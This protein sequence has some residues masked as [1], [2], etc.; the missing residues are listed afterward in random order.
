MVEYFF[1]DSSEGTT[2]NWDIF[3]KFFGNDESIWFGRGCGTDIEGTALNVRV[4]DFLED[5]VIGGR[6]SFT[7]KCEV[8]ILTFFT[9]STSSDKPQT[10]NHC[11]RILG[12]LGNLKNNIVVRHIKHQRGINITVFF[13]HYYDLRFY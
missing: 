5:P 1:E 2:T 8:Q 13:I 9:S 7:A 10:R 3:S 11:F 6:T 4:G 12:S